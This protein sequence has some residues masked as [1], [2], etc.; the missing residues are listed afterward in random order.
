MRDKANVLVFGFDMAYE[1]GPVADRPKTWDPTQVRWD[2]FSFN[3]AVP[4]GM[5]HRRS[6][7]DRAGHFNEMV[8]LQEDW[9]LW[10][11]MA[12][13]GAKFTFVSGKSGIY[14]VRRGTLS[15]SPRLTAPQREAVLANWRAGMPIFT[16]SSN[17]VDSGDPP[18]ARLR[19]VRKIAFVSRRCVIDYN[20]DLA[21]ATLDG[22]KLLV[23]AGFECQAFCGTHFDAAEEVLTEEVLARQRVHYEV[24]NAQIRSYRARM[25]FAS[26]GK[27]PLT[28]FNTASTRANWHDDAKVAA[29][30]AACKIFLTKQRPD[31]VWTYGFDPVSLEIQRLVMWL[32]IPLVFSLDDAVYC[33]ESMFQR[34]DYAVVAS[35]YERQL[36]WDRI[37][38]ACQKLPAVVDP[39]RVQV[40]DR[41]PD[42]VTLVNPEPRKGVHVFARIAEVLS[43]RRPDIP[44]L[45]VEGAGKASFLPQLGVNLSG[46]RNLRIMPNTPD[47]RRFYAMTKLLLM[48]SLMENAGFVA[49]EAMTNGIPVLASSRGGLPETVGNSP[50][51]N[52]LPAGEG[53]SGGF[54]FDIPAR[55]TPETRELPTAKEV[56]PWIETIIR[57]WDDPAEYRRASQAARSA[58]QWRPDR[59]APVYCEFFSR[60]THQP[61]PP[62]V[63]RGVVKT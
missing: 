38:L 21:R 55:Y 47:P 20:S 54:L 34:A 33:D 63:P 25:I 31:V 13:A 56:E 3:P 14:Y 11:R 29:F 24:R 35:E 8:W 23:N 37:G 27:V 39:R 5:S 28:L 4:L 42:Y 9:D 7:L 17:G 60:L 43:R 2:F 61:G 16:P 53:T 46:I 58:Q 26:H 62:L 10:K 6:L 18:T 15:H 12:R 45:I 51:P 22:M 44:L 48:P 41:K 40:A 36:H 32:D 30:L 19:D 49:M 59:L 52:P 1:D 57:L 50:H